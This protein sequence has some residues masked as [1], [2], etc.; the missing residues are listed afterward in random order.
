MTVLYDNGEIQ[1]FADLALKDG[2][3]VL[4]NHFSQDKLNN[5]REAF[6]PLLETHIAR[7]GHL[8]NRGPA[9]YYVTL[10]FT[11]P[12][13]DPDIFEDESILAIVERLVGV[14]AVMCQLACDTP[15]IGSAYQEVHRDTLPLF[16]ETGQETPPFQLAINFPLVDIT[17]QNGPLGSRSR[18]AHDV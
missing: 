7:E 2:F 4:P 5:W 8:Q 1:H 10:P 18:H 9:R 17:M 15:M 6:L 11:Q 16:P 3:C 13:A 12:F 14:D